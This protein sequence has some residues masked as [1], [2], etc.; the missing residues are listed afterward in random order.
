MKSASVLFVCLGNICRSPT[1]EAVFRAQVKAAG[2]ADEIQIDSAGTGDWHIGKAPDHRAQTAGL[3]RGF[4][5][6]ALRA[7][8]V[9]SEDFSRHQW[10]IAMDENNLRDLK[11]L[12]PPTHEKKISLLLDYAQQSTANKNVPDPYH[13]NMADFHRVLD[14]VEDACQGLLAHIQ[15]ELY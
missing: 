11:K 3:E 15:Q 2:L 14:L 10:I 9:T 6:S 5:L 13:G 12:A 4:D 8:L 1:A 7:R